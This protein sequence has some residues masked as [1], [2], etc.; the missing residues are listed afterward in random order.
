MPRST[1]HWQ[2]GL[3]FSLLTAAQWGLAPVLLKALQPVLGSSTIIWFR[4]VIPAFA[5]GCYFL[6]M[7]RD[8]SWRPLLQARNLALLLIAIGG[9]LG[10]YI[11]FMLGLQHIT[12]DA[13]QVIGQL[14][15]LLLLIGG[16][17]IFKEPFSP[18]QWLGLATAIIGMGL[19]FHVPLSKLHLDKY[20]LGL[21]WIVGASCV[22][23]AFGLSQKALG[24]DINP[25]Q[26]LLIIYVIGT[27]V[28]LPAADFNRVPQLDG[29]GVTMLIW[30]SLSTALAYVTLS[31]AM[32][33]WDASRVSA[34]IT[35]TPLF[36][37]AFTAAMTH[38]IP[39]QMRA[40]ELD[41]LSSCGA[42]LLVAGSGIAAIARR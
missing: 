3:L 33:H 11:L 20:S 31:A 16:V 5:V 42:A 9:L 18:L 14:G 2:T 17:L 32:L 23:G 39:G 35:T 24:R 29:L 19:F 21:L 13:S 12:A 37:I 40:A 34:I 36:A 6:L 1:Q 28:Y 10:N 8:L 38:W 22:W 15:P 30:L 4:L 26:S 41:W 27:F 7:R 25:Q